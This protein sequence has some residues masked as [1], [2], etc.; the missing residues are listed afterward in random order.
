DVIREAIGAAAV[1]KYETGPGR[2]IREY[3]V[4]PAAQLSSGPVAQ[5]VRGLAGEYFDNPRL[6]G[7]PRLTR[8]DARMDFRW[9]LNSPGRGIPFDWYSLR[10]T[11][12]ILAR[13]ACG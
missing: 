10:W 1:L 12:A 9:T 4:V 11:G 13:R 7:Q 6:E 5:P 3:D 2:S 8:T